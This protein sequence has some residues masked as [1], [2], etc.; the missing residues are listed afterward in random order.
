MIY[1]SSG[2]FGKK[3]N[4]NSANYT[5]I[6]RNHKRPDYH[7]DD[8]P[9]EKAG[10]LEVGV[11]FKSRLFGFCTRNGNLKKFSYLSHK[12]KILVFTVLNF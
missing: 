8:Q 11:S 4:K 1:P 3:T 5:K 10:E 9:K 12:Y 7:T 6:R 2:F